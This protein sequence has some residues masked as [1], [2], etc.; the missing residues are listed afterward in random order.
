MGKFSDSEVKCVIFDC[1]GVLVDSVSSW[2][3]LH[4]H[5]GTDN[6]LNLKRFI[7][8]ELTDVEFMSSDIKMWKDKQDPIP[9]D[10]LFRAYSGVKLM[11][12]A[13]ELVAE[14]KDKGIFVAIVSAGVD[15][16]VSSIAAMLKVDDW[17]AN[18]FKFNDD[19]TLSDEGICRLH[20][21]KKDVV[22]RKLMSMHNFSPEDCVSIGD[23]EMDLSMIVDESRFIGFNPSRESSLRAFESAGV[24]IIK[25][26]DLMLL[27]P[28]L[29]L[30]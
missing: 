14:L 26:K 3:T 22:I 15:I 23:S 11:E 1:D 6:S 19:E 10:V 8:G 18:G 7:K 16:F 28:Y 12:G 30:E 2:K 21:S 29:G 13:R 24:P 20:A 9:R 5:F 27:K 25:E 4:D 17:I